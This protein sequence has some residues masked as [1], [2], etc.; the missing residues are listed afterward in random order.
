MKVLDVGCGPNKV[1]GAVGV[2]LVPLEGVD[3]V[4][5]LDTF[6]WPFGDDEFDEVVANHFLEHAADLM[7][8]LI[9]LHRITKKDHGRIRIRVPHYTS[10]NFYCDITHTTPF[11]IRSFDHFTY[12]D[13]T[14]YNYYSPVKF[15]L[16]HRWIS[17]A[18]PGRANPWRWV[19]IEWAA[20]RF[21]RF[22]ERLF[23]FIVPASEVQFVLRPI[24]DR[25]EIA[26]RV[27]APNQPAGSQ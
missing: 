11:S 15:A 25:G 6:P 22:Y 19:G 27:P 7:R 5:N 16:E 2:D 24:P 12:E 26:P 8:T 13:R 10:W 23:A 20:N 3:V 18:P 14:G 17:F 1:E 4:H 9:E 21:A